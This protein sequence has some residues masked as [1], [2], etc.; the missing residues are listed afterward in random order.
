MIVFILRSVPGAGK[1][2]LAE[3]LASMKSDLQ[4]SRI[5]CAD[6]YFTDEKG[7][8]NFKQEEIGN[9]HAYCKRQYS[10]AI[11]KKVDFIIVANT[12]TR[13][14]DVNY[15]RNIAIENRYTC[16]VLTV[17]NWHDGKNVHSVPEDVLAKMKDQLIRSIKL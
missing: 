1:S 2:T 11:S 14:S 12:S 4:T 7:N 3:T 10:D 6:D 13:A 17:E 16:F 5:C 15:Y 8:Y 9:A